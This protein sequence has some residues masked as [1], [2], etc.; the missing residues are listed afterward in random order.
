MDSRL[1]RGRAR[2]LRHESP[3][4]ESHPAILA[5]TE[6]EQ[7]IWV[8]HRQGVDG[9]LIGEW[10]GLR[11]DQVCRAL[12]TIKEKLRFL[13][14]FRDAIVKNPTFFRSYVGCS[15]QNCGGC[16]GCPIGRSAT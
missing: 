6:K 16:P 1:Y 11:K 9:R 14:D 10:V 13:A 7:E 15:A 5:L 3:D 8:F 4:H 12:K 2:L